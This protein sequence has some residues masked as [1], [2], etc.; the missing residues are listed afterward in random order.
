MA[1]TIANMF[2]GIGFDFDKNSVKDVESAMDSFKSKA[3][4]VGAAAA[5]A[6]GLKKTGDWA[7]AT[8]DLGKFS[9]RF[10]VAA[11][12][13]SAF[14]RALQ[15]AGGSAGEFQGVIAS[16]SQKQ[17]LTG[18]DKATM[19][20]GAARDGIAGA[21]QSVIDATDATEGFLKAADAIQGMSPA[22]QERFFQT[23]GFSDAQVRLLRE[24]RTEIMKTVSKE[25]QMRNITDDMTKTSAEFNDEMQN[26]GTMLA[27][28]SDHVF[29]PITERLTGI[30][31]GMNDWLMVN[32]EFLTSGIDSF[33]E[34]LGDGIY[35]AA[36]A[37]AL[38]VAAKMLKGLQTFLFLLESIA[39]VRGLTS[40]AGAFG[41]IGKAIGF[42]GKIALRAIPAVGAIMAA[43]EAGSWVFD[44]LTGGGDENPK[45]DAAKAAEKDAAKGATGKKVD[46]SGTQTV[47]VEVSSKE[48]HIE[49]KVK[50][51]QS[52]ENQQTIDAMATPQRG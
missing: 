48:D 39:A 52:T 33:F 38:L 34:T 47:K 11:S 29:L 13:V 45:G 8:D 28:I 31:R 25:K 10:G 6:F 12:D 46:V 16:L 22:K 35:F 32:F 50:D 4:M 19:L 23:M 20:A 27:G 15:H 51:I 36:A 30:V 9:E 42:V 41:K 40:V 26:L 24:G 37:V 21:V 17:S 14:D 2:V 5:G 18:A 3:I 49:T 7:K 43:V 44:K 1:S